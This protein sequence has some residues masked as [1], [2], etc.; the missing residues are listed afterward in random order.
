MVGSKLLYAGAEGRTRG[1]VTGGGTGDREGSERVYALGF[2]VELILRD[3]DGSVKALG[4][5]HGTYGTSGHERRRRR[6]K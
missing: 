2:P 6:A 3:G 5:T 1:V 4:E